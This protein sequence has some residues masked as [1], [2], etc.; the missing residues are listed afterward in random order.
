M[1][2]RAFP[3]TPMISASM[4]LANAVVAAGPG[5]LLQ[6]LPCGVIAGCSGFFTFTLMGD[7]SGL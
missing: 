3:F 5:Q 4:A 1:Q 2:Q 7:R 6:H